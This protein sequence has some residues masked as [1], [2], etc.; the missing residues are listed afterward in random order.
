MLPLLLI[1]FAASC[2]TDVDKDAYV[3]RN[4][5]IV[6][7]LPVFPESKQ[8]AMRSSAYRDPEKVEADRTTVGYI[9]TVTYGVSPETKTGA[10]ADFY[11]RRLPG[12]RLVENFGRATQAALPPHTRQRPR[13]RQ[14]RRPGTG[15]LASKPIPVFVFDRGDSSVSVNLDN[16]PYGTFEIVVDHEHYG[17]NKYNRPGTKR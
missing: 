9:T 8:L 16:L 15:P 14:S 17:E 5:A 13:T 6:R 10:V 7:S 3:E 12:W 4:Q 11:K 1:L 2:G